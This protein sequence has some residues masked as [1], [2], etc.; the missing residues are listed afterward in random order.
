MGFR[1]STAR[2]MISELAMKQP[3]IRILIVGIVCLSAVAGTVFL[4]LNLGHRCEST[5]CQLVGVSF[6]MIQA[7]EMV[8]RGE[9]S[10]DLRAENIS[11]RGGFIDDAGVI[12]INLQS[13]ASVVA[14]KDQDSTWLCKLYPKSNLSKQVTRYLIEDCF[15]KQRGIDS[16]RLSNP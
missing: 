1:G 2:N 11:F 14:R 3:Y 10:I 6:T 9:R 15:R 13:G 7:Q 5:S 12:V 4:V 8:E 16:V